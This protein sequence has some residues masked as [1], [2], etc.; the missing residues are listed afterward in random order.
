MAASL[1]S[2]NPT[3]SRTLASPNK[4]SSFATF[5]SPFLRFNSTSVAS[6]FKPLVSR[7]ASSSFVTRSA[8][9]PQERK[10]F[11]GLCY[12]V[13]DNIDTDQ[14]I[15]AEFLTLVPSN[16]E[17]YEKLGSYA[18]V[19]LPASYK[20]RFVQPGAAGAK[21]VVAQSYARIFFRNSVATGEVYPLD[22]EVRVCD[23][24]TTGDVATVELR[25]GDSILINHTT[26]KEYK[27]KPI[28][29]AGP[30]IDA[31]GIFAYAR[32]AGMIPSAAA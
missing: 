15:P 1:Q 21:A 6:N 8:A 20:E 31:G 29:D 3:L 9:E 23:E 26:G 19:G 13:G 14:I 25:E 4:P 28:G 16:P 22:S 32:K 10:T 5:R 24:C 12:V 11:H 30:V 2:A 18:L 17:E 27:L 7:E